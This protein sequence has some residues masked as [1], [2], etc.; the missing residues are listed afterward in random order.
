[1]LQKL[2]STFSSRTLYYRF[3]KQIK[4]LSPEL[5]V[6]LTQIDY[7]REIALAAIHHAESGEEMLG[8]GRL[9]GV[10]GAGTSEFSVVIG[11]PWQGLGI[12]AQL[13]AH[14]IL[15]AKDRHIRNIWGLIQRENKNM[16]ELARSLDFTIIGDPDDPQVE[17]TLT[18]MP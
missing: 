4:T 12:G 10:M 13:L 2:W 17:A 11:D 15:I 5:L 1:M 16:I 18:I 6:T 9:Y 3:S 7:D 8:V 14:L